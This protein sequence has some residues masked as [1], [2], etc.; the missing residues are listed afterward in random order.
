MNG[1]FELSTKVIQNAKAKGLMLATAES[2]TGGMIAASLTD[3][4]GSSAV[5]DRGFVTYSYPSKIE[6]LNVSEEMLAEYGAVSEPVAR[7]MAFGALSTSNADLAIAVTGVAGPGADGDK[8]EGLVWFALASARGVEAREVNFGAIGRDK[9]RMATV[10]TAL[11]WL[12][13]KI[14]G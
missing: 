7:Q 13:D 8:A 10:E 12:S 3:V 9:V 6:T 2:C 11:N 5:F 4:A 1:H 14:S